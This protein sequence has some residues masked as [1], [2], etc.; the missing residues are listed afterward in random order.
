MHASVSWQGAANS[1][2]AEGGQNRVPGADWVGRELGRAGLGAPSSLEGASHE[3]GSPEAGLGWGGAGRALFFSL[4]AVNFQWCC[5][6]VL[7]HSVVSDSA[8]PWTVAGQ[9]AL[10]MGSSRKEDWRGCHAS[11]GGLPHPG[12]EAVSPVL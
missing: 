5:A 7:S 2:P 10:S 6:C 9:A 12:T 3:Q 8:T 11:P 4:T 1:R